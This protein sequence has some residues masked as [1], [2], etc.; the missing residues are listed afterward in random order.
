MHYQQQT[1]DDI[2]LKRY[3]TA[4]RLWSEEFF[5]DQKLMK[6]INT[7]N[8]QCLECFKLEQNYNNAEKTVGSGL[9][10]LERK[11]DEAEKLSVKNNEGVTKLGQTLDDYNKRKL[12]YKSELQNEDRSDNKVFNKAEKTIKSRIEACHERVAFVKHTI[13]SI[14]V[15]ET[16]RNP[17]AQEL[18][19]QLRAL[20]NAQQKDLKFLES[21]TK[22]EL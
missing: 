8:E 3:E 20:L 7:V 11:V 4:R 22:T 15:D 1:I 21:K 18:L 12:Q 6:S 2:R 16:L 5:E 17:K 14:E 9:D 10:I 19:N 13:D